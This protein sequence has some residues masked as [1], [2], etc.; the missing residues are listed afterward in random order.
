MTLDDFKLLE[1]KGYKS[2]YIVNI[3]LHLTHLIRSCH[4]LGQ[5]AN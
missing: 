1:V 3:F 4:N 2:L 5:R